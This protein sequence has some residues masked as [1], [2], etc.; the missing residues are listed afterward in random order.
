MMIA[1]DSGI[2]LLHDTYPGNRADATQFTL[3][4]GK[5][6]TR[7]EAVTGRT[8]D[9]TVTFDRGNNLDKNIA[10]LRSCEQ[11]MHFVG[12]L[13]R[14]RSETCLTSRFQTTCRSQG[15]G[16]PERAPTVRS[17]MYLAVSIP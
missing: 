8:T 14:L 2:P 7:Y 9:I 15:T 13:Q 12:G 6:K 4:L 17:E 5:L 1:S 11:P 10:F 16:Y 3:M